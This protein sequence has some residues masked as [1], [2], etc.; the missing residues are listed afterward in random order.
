M[1][2][3]NI[4]L[5]GATLILVLL[6]SSST[7][8]GAI[9]SRDKTQLVQKEK[10]IINSNSPEKLSMQPLIIFPASSF[11][12]GCP[13]GHIWNSGDTPL[14]N[15]EWTISTAGGLFGRL[16]KS[17]SGTIPALPAN[18]GMVTVEGAPV[19]GFCGLK[20]SYTVICDQGFSHGS[21][22]FGRLRI[23]KIYILP[24]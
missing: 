16:D 3:K 12:V 24:A 8:A 21:L 17:V 23:D 9:P 4:L 20:I 13:Q 14:T 7:G 2:K 18:S 11:M 19:F 10:N 6:L 1:K 5:V 15:V 22:C